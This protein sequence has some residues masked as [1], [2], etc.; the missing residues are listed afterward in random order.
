MA[1]L[2]KKP[3]TETVSN[4][5]RTRRG[6]Q[7]TPRVDICETDEALTIFADLPGVARD[8]LEI[9]FEND[10][11]T[12]RG[13]ARIRHEQRNLV[14]AEYGVG[15]F[16]RTFTIGESIAAD[17]ISAELA[18]GVLTIQLP[19]TERVKPRRIEVKAK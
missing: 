7:F 2:T 8:D 9:Q 10:S 11:L 19:K 18:N 6:T 1:S 4:S 14:H 12:I 15:D 3:E 16:R 13:Q 5:E 17:Q